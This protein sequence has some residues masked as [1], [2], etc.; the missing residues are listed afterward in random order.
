MFCFD[1]ELKSGFGPVR[2]HPCN[3]RC[4]VPAPE[5]RPNACS[6]FPIRDVVVLGADGPQDVSMSIITTDLN[7]VNLNAAVK[8]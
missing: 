3:N 1:A 5:H 8:S 6:L 2:H 4:A 7:T